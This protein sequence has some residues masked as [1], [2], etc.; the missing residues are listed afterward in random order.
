MEKLQA[1]LPL[2][3]YLAGLSQ[4]CDDCSRLQ[5]TYHVAQ[6][7]YA[8]MY[9]TNPKL[10]IDLSLELQSSNLHLLHS[11]LYQTSITQ[12]PRRLDRSYPQLNTFCHFETNR[13]Y[14]RYP[15]FR[16]DPLIDH[17]S[18]PSPASANQRP[19]DR[20]TDCFLNRQR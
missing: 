13:A 2:K 8:H 3:V 4:T 19:L 1:K 9:L 11:S 12:P 6:I 20:T 10:M 17:P 14:Y 5:G 15:L 16:D 7:R 18:L